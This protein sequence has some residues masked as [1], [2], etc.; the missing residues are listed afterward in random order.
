MQDGEDRG[1]QEP[2]SWPPF[3]NLDSLDPDCL[4]TRQTSRH[5]R[6]AEE[7]PEWTGKACHDDELWRA[8]PAAK[9]SDI[10]KWTEERGGGSGNSAW[11]SFGAEEGTLG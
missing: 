7:R 11:S 4:P 6:G 2:S 1:P 3:P 9:G 8:N 10:E 5:P